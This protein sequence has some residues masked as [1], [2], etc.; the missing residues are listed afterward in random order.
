VIREK[1]KTLGNLSVLSSIFSLFEISARNHNHCKR[2]MTKWMRTN[3]ECLWLR[4][5]PAFSPS[6]SAAVY[7]LGPGGSALAT[8]YRLSMGP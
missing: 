8:V 5:L 2:Q 3:A 7:L 4:L 6:S 1:D